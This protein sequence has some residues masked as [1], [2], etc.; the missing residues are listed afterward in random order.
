MFSRK[1]QHNSKARAGI[2]VRLRTFILLKF[3]NYKYSCEYFIF[4]LI[5]III[6]IISLF[7]PYRDL[8]IYFIYLFF[9]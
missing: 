6:Y 8:S 7:I 2:L 4:I 3:L 5:P 9:Y 1:M